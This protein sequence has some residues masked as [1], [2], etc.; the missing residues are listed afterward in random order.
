MS[1][2]S[3]AA[4][5]IHGDR[6]TDAALSAALLRVA[7]L[8]LQHIAME[9]RGGPSTDGRIALGDGAFRRLAPPAP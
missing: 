6:S 8:D 7:E 2:P 5:H 9:S 4:T 1:L 3:P